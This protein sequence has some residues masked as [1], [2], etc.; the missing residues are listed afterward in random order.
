MGDGFTTRPFR[1]EDLDEVL[2][3]LRLSLG[4]TQLLQRTKELFTWKHLD[5][6]FGESIL[7]VAEHSGAIVAMR[8]LM[9]WVLQTPGGSELNCLRPVDTAT[10][11]D[12]RRRG[13][14][15][16]LTMEALEQARSEGVHVVF[17]TP[18]QE[19]RPGYLKMGWQDVGDVKVMVKPNLSRL[20]R[21][22]RDEADI[23]VDHVALSGL[24]LVERPSQGLR[25]RR[26]TEYGLWRF[27]SHP[28]ASYHRYVAGDSSAIVRAGTRKGRT[29]LV[30]SE[31]TGGD[32]KAAIATALRGSR[33]Q[34]AVASFAR[35][36]PERRA[37][38]R[39]GLW[40]VPFFSA[41]RLVCRPL[42][43]VDLDLTSMSNWDLALSDLELL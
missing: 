29:E 24:E 33:A 36:T 2:E 12:F 4:E 34:Y 8:A 21:D 37:A 10:H 31:V 32:P 3:V 6:P 20:I 15:R 27:G 18:N 23:A 39:N 26:T 14:F 35:G 22:D 5:N 30:I 38:L 9:R 43:E 1:Y 13:L 17:N 40:P 11:P 19:S 42:I 25:T 28:R 41:L 7:L 16:R